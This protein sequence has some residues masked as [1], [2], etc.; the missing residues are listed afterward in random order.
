[1]ASSLAVCAGLI[2]LGAIG[3]LATRF[4][5]GY[6]ISPP[7]NALSNLF[8]SNSRN[9]VD[10]LYKPLVDQEEEEQQKQTQPEQ[11]QMQPEQPQMQMQSQMQKQEKYYPPNGLVLSLIHI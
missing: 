11:P 4:F 2:S 7:P 3:T 1:M 10:P 9:Q 5:L 8:Q 6:D